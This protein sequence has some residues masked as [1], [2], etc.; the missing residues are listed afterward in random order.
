MTVH[1][2]VVI[3]WPVHNY[4]Y[5]LQAWVGQWL[6]GADGFDWWVSYAVGPLVFFLSGKVGAVLCYRTP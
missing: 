2:L 4:R 5:K 6:G 1:A 3:N